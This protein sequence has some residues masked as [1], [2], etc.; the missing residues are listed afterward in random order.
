MNF[1][2]TWVLALM[3]LTL[4]VPLTVRDSRYSDRA[5]WVGFNA[6]PTNHRVKDASNMVYSADFTDI[7][8]IE[9]HDRTRM[10]HIFC[11]VSSCSRNRKVWMSS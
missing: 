8:M 6:S 1:S 4:V 9:A 10:I 7:Y 5:D 2:K 3:S 11:G